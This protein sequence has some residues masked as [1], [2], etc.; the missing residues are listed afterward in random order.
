MITDH[1]KMLEWLDRNGLKPEHLP[2]LAKYKLYPWQYKFITSTNRINL[3]VAS[4]QSG[5]SVA[6]QKKTVWLAS[7]PQYWPTFFPRRANNA[8]MMWYLYPDRGTMKREWASKWPACLPDVPKSHPF[9]AHYGYSLGPRKEGLPEYIKFNT[10][11]YIFF[12][13][14]TQDL[15]HL[16]ATTV[17]YIGC[18]EEVPIPVYEELAAR[19]LATGGQFNSVFTATL[20]QKFFY[21]AI[22]RVGSPEETLK[23]AFKI[24]VSMYDCLKYMDGS[25]SEH[26]TEESIEAALDFYKDDPDMVKKRVYGRFILGQGKAFYSY[27]KDVCEVENVQVTRQHPIF[28]IVDPGTGGEKAHPAGILIVQHDMERHKLVVLSAWRGD[29]VATTS[30][31]ILAQVERMING[32]GTNTLIYD[33]AAGDFKLTC[34]E[35]RPNLYLI[36]AKKGRKEGFERVNSYLEAGVIEIPKKCPHGVPWWEESQIEK[37]HVEL[38]T[39]VKV[40]ET[41]DK[42]PAIT[43]D[44]TDCLRYACMHINIPIEKTT[45]RG[46]NNKPAVKMIRRG[47]SLYYP[48]E[49]ENPITVAQEA[50]FWEDQFNGFGQ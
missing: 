29:G 3:C 31:T 44:L 4:N 33:G 19:L 28:A 17:D 26:V 30:N 41:G 9:H 23:N 42:R 36:A 1:V 11:M 34:H 25:P 24:N 45:P 8:N 27:K 18:D 7:T 47:R 38:A 12:L 14:Y 10:G 15:S 6:L 22:E 13:Y 20:G 43:D 50:L 5:K 39:V 40:P 2:H 48:E 16:Q 35:D 37:L 21:D 49:L 32:L 46:R